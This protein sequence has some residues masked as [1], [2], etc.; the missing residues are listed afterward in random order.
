MSN[1][2]Q[3]STTPSLAAQPVAANKQYGPTPTAANP[4]AAPA[5]GGGQHAPAPIPAPSFG[6]SGYQ[7][8]RV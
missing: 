8:C 6:W 3:H 7:V 4:A 1:Y 2:Y 5:A